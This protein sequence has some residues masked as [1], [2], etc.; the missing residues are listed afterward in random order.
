MQAHARAAKIVT[1]WHRAT[2][3]CAAAGLR[4]ALFC[5][6]SPLSSPG[7]VPRV[8]LI[9][10]RT[11]QQPP[12][13]AAAA[14]ARGAPLGVS[15]TQASGSGRAR[16]PLFRPPSQQRG[17][18]KP[19]PHHVVHG[20]RRGAEQ[21]PLSCAAGAGCV[22]RTLEPSD[23]WH[24][25]TQLAVSWQRETAGAWAVRDSSGGHRVERWVA[26]A[27]RTHAAGSW[28]GLQVL[29]RVRPG[30]AAR[31][32]PSLPG[33]SKCVEGLGSWQ[34]AQVAVNDR[35]RGGCAGRRRRLAHGANRVCEVG[36]MS[37]WE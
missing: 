18:G 21:H 28:Q 24:L 5:V 33:A 29:P 20:A 30:Y 36:G 14:R 34:G 9:L 6:S 4:H 31:M 7:S 22:R 19:W 3:G 13:A 32:L 1:S 23:S 11:P 27:A 15:A 37:A 25:E 35:W 17:K 12:A 2:R 16:R 26:G 10:R 8:Q